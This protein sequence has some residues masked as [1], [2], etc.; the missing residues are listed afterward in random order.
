MMTELLIKSGI[1]IVGLYLLW[2]LASTFLNHP[3]IP[4]ALVGYFAVKWFWHR[5][6]QYQ[7]PIISKYPYLIAAIVAYYLWRRWQQRRAI[8]AGRLASREASLQDLHYFVPEFWFLGYLNEHPEANNERGPFVL[9]ITTNGSKTGGVDMVYSARRCQQLVIQ[10]A[11]ERQRLA[12]ALK[13]D[14]RKQPELLTNRDLKMVPG[15]NAGKYPFYLKTI[16]KD[17]DGKSQ[18]GMANE[19]ALDFDTTRKQQYYRYVLRL[20]DGMLYVGITNNPTRRFKEH[21]GDH[22]STM[23]HE[24]GVMGLVSLEAIGEMTYTEAEKAEDLETLRLMRKW[25]PSWVRGGH[26]AMDSFT[27]V[28]HR[29]GEQRRAIKL[30]YHYRL[31]QLL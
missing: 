26:W 5:P 10:L 17:S 3:F 9:H 4:W 13:S 16:L 22:G 23:T 29:L 28:A 7:G 31:N 30:M 6:W 12:Q 27:A 25:S 8:K 15:T 19:S 18:I 11:A 2:L 14:A 1:V 21:S 20:E 24:H